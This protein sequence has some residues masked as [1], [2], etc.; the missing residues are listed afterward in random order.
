VKGY[1]VNITETAGEQPLN[2]ITDV[3]VEK[4]NVSDVTFVAPAIKAT[5]EVSGQKVKKVY[6]DGAY[7]SP[8]LDEVT[9]D[10]DMVYTGLSGA[11]SRYELQLQG[12]DLL[13]TDTYTGVQY[14]GTLVKK[15][16]RSKENVWK[17]KTAE[18]VR[19]F[20]SKSIR[21]SQ[22]RKQLQ[23]RPITELHKRNN[24]EATI[25]HLSHH[26]HKNKTRYR[27]KLKQTLWAICRCLWI[28]LVRII[29]YIGQLAPNNLKRRGKIAIFDFLREIFISFFLINF[30]IFP[31]AKNFVFSKK[32]FKIMLLLK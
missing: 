1:S 15:T 20:N 19:Y 25:F 30:Y 17:V 23:Q 18:G 28:N 10:I 2:L 11:P 4:A 32:S 26:L 7:Q 31:Q 21:A 29:K 12:E 3:Q 24:V 16:K 22:L 5:E 14:S 6:L 27:G 8:E 9:E 13:V